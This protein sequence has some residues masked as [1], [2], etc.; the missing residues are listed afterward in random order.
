MKNYDAALFM[1]VKYQISIHSALHNNIIFLM[2][3]NKYVQLKTQHNKV[4]CF[5]F[6]FLFF[7]FFNRKK[8]GRGFTSDWNKKV[9]REEKKKAHCLIVF[10]ENDNCDH[11]N[12]Y[13][14]TQ[15]KEHCKMTLEKNNSNCM[16][17]GCGHVTRQACRTHWQFGMPPTEMTFQ[18]TNLPAAHW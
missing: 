12:P 13:T 5:Q 4:W 2:N 1:T 16:T 11:Q 8:K 15:K 17:G 6:F 14:H 7:F 10:R 18:I 3:E 9:W